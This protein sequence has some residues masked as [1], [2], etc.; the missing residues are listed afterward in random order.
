MS[1]DDYQNV[2][3]KLSE[4]IKKAR[5]ILHVPTEQKTERASRIVKL[6]ENLQDDKEKA[7]LMSQILKLNNHS[8]M[9]LNRL[10]MREEK[11]SKNE[12]S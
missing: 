4:D 7:V 1:D 5:F 11:L 12:L 6:L 10:A 2:C 3:Q 8:A 9:I